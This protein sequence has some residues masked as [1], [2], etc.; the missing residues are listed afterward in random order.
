MM[1]KLI[2][3]L[4]L[5]S[6]L[7]SCKK[8]TG[9]DLSKAQYK[10]VLTFNW[11]AQNFST[12][13][14]SNA[15]FSPLIGWSHQANNTFFSVDS[16]ASPG[17]K[18]MAERGR[19]TPLDNELN[20]KI[21]NGEGYQMYIGSDLAS[22]VGEIKIDVEVTQ[23]FPEVTLVS[24]LAPSPDWYIA[25]LNVNLLENG[26]FVKEK[27]VDVLIYDAGTDSGV[28]FTSANLVTSPPDSISIIIT[29]PLGNGSVVNPVIATA[30]FIK[31]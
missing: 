17:I 6:V 11:N 4:L 19:T 2:P 27:K 13:Y 18:D 7:F 10:V 3:V 24:M 31:Q 20:A 16:L 28:T 15:H 8:E 30:H 22:G 5:L 25:A 9:R 29:S 21:A 1:R 12:D 14:P 26:S 23:N